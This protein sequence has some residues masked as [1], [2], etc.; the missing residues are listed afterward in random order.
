MVFLLNFPLS[1]YSTISGICTTEG[2]VWEKQ[3]GFFHSHMV[4]LVHGKGTSGFQ[5]LVMD[6]VHDIKMEL[7]KRVGAHVCI[8]T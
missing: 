4:E 3:R 5:D 7:G 6:E 1:F 2:E 8:Y